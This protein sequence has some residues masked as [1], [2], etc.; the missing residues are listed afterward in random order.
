MKNL[1]PNN[2]ASKGAAL[3]IVLALVVLASALGL[4]YFSRTTTNRQLAQSSYNDTSA[5]LLA[6][7]ALDITVNDLKQEIANNSTITQANIQPSRYPSGIPNDNPNLVRYSSRNAAASRA[8]NIS[9]N[10]DSANRRG[11]T[12]ARWNSHY[13]IPPANATGS[14]STPVNSFVPPDWVFVTAQGPNTA[15]A[16]NAVVG[17][18][19]FAVYNEGGLI[20]MNL[21]GFPLYTSLSQPGPPGRH[22]SPARRM[23]PRDDSNESEIML[24]ACQAPN[25]TPDHINSTLSTGVPCSL[26]FNTNHKPD[27]FGVNYLPRGLAINTTNGNITGTPVS[28]GTFTV[29]LS[30]TNSCGVGTAVLNLM[31]QGFPSP[32]STPWPINLAR[33]GTLAF[34]DLATLPSVPT[35]ITPTTQVG[36]MTGFPTSNQINKLVGWRNYATTQQSLGSFESPSF[37]LATAD[38]YARYF[39][40]SIPPFT[41]PFTGVSAVAFTQAGQN[42]NPRT[43][44][45]VTTRQQLIQL[46]RKVGFSQ[47]L[48]QYLG[49]FAREYN[50]PAASWP[51]LAG[52]ISGARWDM[53][54]LQLV[55]PDSWLYPGNH[56]VGHAYGKQRHSDIGQLF[57]LVWVNGNF[58]AMGTR[59]TD[60]NYYGH[61]RYI[62]KLKQNNDPPL[63]G[64]TVDFFQIIDYAMNQAVG[65]PANSPNHLRNTFNLGASLIDQYDTD[66]LF[67]I[68]PGAQNPITGNTI[69]IIDPV[70]DGNPADYVYGIEGMS[71]DT[72]VIDSDKPP[73]APYPQPVPSNYNLLNRRFE[74]VGE[75]GYSYSSASSLASKILDFAS[76]TSNDRALLDFFTYNMAGVREG[77]LNLNTRNGP[78]LASVINGALLHDF[79]GSTII[80]SPLTSRDNALAAGQAIVQETTSNA[81][82]HGPVLNRGDVTRL[83][84]A[85]VAALPGVLGTS[86]EAKQ[87]IARALAETGQARTWNLLIDVIAQTGQYLPSATDIN[88]A[89]KFIVQGDKR[90]WLHIAIDRDDGTI[91]GTQLEELAE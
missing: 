34:A 60:P 51:Q 15:P 24:A 62:G 5:D 72:P 42:G 33:K 38:N 85:A 21:G 4:A 68:P 74:N 44:Q 40:G 12:L 59:F 82:G 87:S 53:N 55:I 91:L 52:S 56:G 80:P 86:D 35:A 50:R 16:P 31:I 36:D 73:F 11:I 37:V 7:S 77:T 14:D 63:Q 71:F 64:G 17:R 67:D 41:T 39:L 9:S 19:A 75:F 70:G 84:Q 81:T 47:S 27:S 2:G 46:Q 26:L 83:A 78:V 57:G 10:A 8:S 89:D 54:N 1:H 79:G 22:S 3:I 6:R 69:T 66:D 48:L 88:Q 30:A 49:T 58:G 65:L 90:Y 43:D 45:A 20:D 29:T 25:F 18:Y 13:L 32:D 61:W 28:P 23:A 76:S